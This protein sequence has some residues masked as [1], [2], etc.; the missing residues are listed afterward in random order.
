M[1]IRDKIFSIFKNKEK[2]VRDIQKAT[3]I[4]KS[5]AHHHKKQIEK[6]NENEESS[7][8]ETA[9][10]YNFLKRMVIATIYTFCIKGGLGAGRIKEFFE[11]IK[12]GTHVAISESTILLIIKE[13]E[14]LIL[15]FKEV[16]NNEIKSKIKEIKLILGVD[17]TWFD[18]MYLV[19]KELSS[20]YIIMEQTAKDRS[21]DTWNEGLKKTE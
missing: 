11:F 16:K 19:C 14:D 3:A 21:S 13:V 17:E 20:G 15:E 6:R 12:I 8:W 9:T 7:F 18:Q 1:S 5:T 2:T 10:G 4:P